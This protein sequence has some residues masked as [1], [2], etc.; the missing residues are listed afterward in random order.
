[1]ILTAVAE[2]HRHRHD[3]AGRVV[4]GVP[5]SESLAVPMGMD[6]KKVSGSFKYKSESEDD[7]QQ[8]WIIAGEVPVSNDTFNT[9]NTFNIKAHEPDTPYGIDHTFP[10][11]PAGVKG[12]T[13]NRIKQK[14]VYFA[15]TETRSDPHERMPSFGSFKASIKDGKM[16]FMYSIKKANEGNMLVGME[17]Y[18]ELHNGMKDEKPYKESGVPFECSLAVDGDTHGTDGIIAFKATKA[19]GK[20]KVVE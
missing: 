3:T 18:E 15:G 6:L 17:D 5:S 12:R 20:G 2:L 7:A 14:F 4:I 11:D 16:K 1:M 10:K 8:K 13:G 19:K 9:V